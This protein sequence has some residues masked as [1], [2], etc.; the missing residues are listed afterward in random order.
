MRLQWVRCAACSR[1]NPRRNRRTRSTGRSAS[2]AGRAR[3]RGRPV[4]CLRLR[5]LVGRVAAGL[6]FWAGAP[7]P[8][9]TPVADARV[10][11]ASRRH[12]TDA[13][14]GRGDGAGRC[15]RA[16]WIATSHAGQAGPAPRSAR[17]GRRTGQRRPARFA[18]RERTVACARALVPHGRAVR[19]GRGRDD[20]GRR[21]TVLGRRCRRRLP[22]APCGVGARGLPCA[23][24]TGGVR[25]CDGA[26]ARIGPPACA[27]GGEEERSWSRPL[28]ASTARSAATRA[29]SSRAGPRCGGRSTTAACSRTR[30]PS[31]ADLDR[32]CSRGGSR[33]PSVDGGSPSFPDPASDFGTFRTPLVVGPG[34]VDGDL[35]PRSD[36]GARSSP[37]T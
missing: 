11:L 33:T 31:D 23:A 34:S 37:P 24:R 35:Q 2:V 25:R 32:R 36:S 20:A 29:G 30:S 15:A 1:T 19:P 4:R 3:R 21:G 6:R 10:A 22:V 12:R 17:S 5:H 13:D 16:A 8:V 28:G 18:P 26:R 27:R 14:A 9:A 7:A